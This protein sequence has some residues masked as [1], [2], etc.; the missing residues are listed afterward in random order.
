MLVMP[1]KLFANPGPWHVSQPEVIPAWL[2]WAPAKVFIPTDGT[3]PV[4]TLLTW[5]VSHAAV[6]GT[7]AG[8]SPAILMGD[9]P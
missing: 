9:T 5:H 3:S 8:D 7:C 4:G 1:K 6:V 2:N